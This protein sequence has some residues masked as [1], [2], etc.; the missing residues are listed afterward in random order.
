[1]ADEE[2]PTATADA[3]DDS[4]AAQGQEA[5]TKDAENPEKVFTQSEVDRRVTEALR[6]YQANQDAKA[7][8]MKREQEQ[9]NAIKEG[10]FEK[11]LHLVQ[12]ELDAIKAETR[13]NEYK[14]RAHDVLRELNLSQFADVLIPGTS[15]TEE[16]ISRA[17]AFQNGIQRGI[18]TEVKRKLD[19]G[20]QRVP[21]NTKSPE[22]KRIDE[23][24][25]DEFVDWKKAN[26]LV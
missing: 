11:A 9:I 19:T 6:T 5:E 8:S 10:E 13:S 3:T 25:R 21:E 12:S 14:V 7:E 4:G 17:K 26:G 22:P 1:M 2:T 24:T 23:M 18:E 16:L 15:D 20:A